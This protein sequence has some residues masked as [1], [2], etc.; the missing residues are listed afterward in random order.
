[1]P[2]SEIGCPIFDRRRRAKVGY[3][4][5][6]DPSFRGVETIGIFAAAK[7]AHLSD[8]K[9]VA[10]MGHPILVARSDM[11]HPSKLLDTPPSYT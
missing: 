5:Q 7:I 10:K 3:R 6:H 1:M 9:A 4:A 11:R 8:D 2:I